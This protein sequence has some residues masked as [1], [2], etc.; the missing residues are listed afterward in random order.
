MAAL[1]EPFGDAG[2]VKIGPFVSDV[3]GKTP[4]TDLNIL[5]ANTLLSKNNGPFVQ[6]ADLSAATHD[7]NGWYDVGLA[8]EHSISKDENYKHLF[9]CGHN[10]VWQ[11]I[12]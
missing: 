1:Q 12:K 7:Q 5:R 2:T 6:K 11:K 10:R 3:D 4:I 8:I 9:A